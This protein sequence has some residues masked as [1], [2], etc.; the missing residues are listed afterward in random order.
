LKSVNCI[1]V[2]IHVLLIVCASYPVL[3]AASRRSGATLGR[4]SWYDQGHTTAS[5]E[6]FQPFAHTAA[7]RTLPFGTKLRVVNAS[8]GASTIVRINDRGPA[9][10]TGRV[11]DLSR[12]AAAAIGM[13]RQGS[14]R[15]QL[16]RLN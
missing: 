9:A 7:H 10:W 1:D 13:V 5:G 4:A 16:E 15:V 3:G 12:G 11:L 8:T 2:S 6:R 14:Q